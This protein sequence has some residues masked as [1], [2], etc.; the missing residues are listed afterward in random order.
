MQKMNLDLK[1]ADEELYMQVLTRRTNERTDIGISCA[2]IGAQKK[3]KIENQL[4]LNNDSSLLG[5]GFR[6]DYYSLLPASVVQCP[7]SSA[8]SRGLGSS[9][10]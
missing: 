6:T 2:P 10:W 4:M 9:C 5:F 1:D 7:A 8:R 3:K